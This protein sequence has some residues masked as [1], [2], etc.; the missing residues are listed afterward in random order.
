MGDMSPAMRHSLLVTVTP[1]GIAQTLVQQEGEMQETHPFVCFLSALTTSLTP[2]LSCLPFAAF[3]T[4]LRARL[5][6][7]SSA[8]GVAIG[9]RR[10]FLEPAVPFAITG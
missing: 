1:L 5:L 3:F 6:S 8:R 7:L 9:L 10:S 4:S 2:L